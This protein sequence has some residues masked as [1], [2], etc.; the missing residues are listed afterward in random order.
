MKITKNVVMGHFQPREEFSIRF[1]II[2]QKC[3]CMT[4][5]SAGQTAYQELLFLKQ[6][7]EKTNNKLLLFFI[8]HKYI[9]VSLL[10]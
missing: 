8:K 1:G 9:K 4:G 3:L 10:Y 7:F 5:A 6:Q 2:L